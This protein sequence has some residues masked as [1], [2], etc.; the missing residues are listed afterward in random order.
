MNEDISK[1]CLNNALGNSKYTSPDILKEILKILANE[2]RKKIREKI[3]SSKFCILVDEALDESNQE[4]MADILSIGWASKDVHDV[5]LF[6]SKLSSII[7]LVGA[8]PKRHS[9]LKIAQKTEIKETL[10]SGELETGT[11]ANQIRT[12]TQPEATR[13][14]SHYSSVNRLIDMFG[15]TCT[16]L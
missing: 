10:N 3:E 4:R 7:N 13:W 1:V 6:F 16:V 14:S 5:W 15:A 11:G 8:S 2:V 12:L 9:E